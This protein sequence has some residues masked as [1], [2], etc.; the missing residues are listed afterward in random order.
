M[1]RERWTNVW[2][3]L[4]QRVVVF[5]LTTTVTSNVNYAMQY[6]DT[7]SIHTT[8]KYLQQKYMV[9]C[10]YSSGKWATAQINH[11][12]QHTYVSHIAL[13]LPNA[14]MRRVGQCPIIHRFGWKW[15]WWVWQNRR[16]QH[17]KDEQVCPKTSCH[18]IKSSQLITVSGKAKKL[19]HYIQ[20]ASG[21]CAA[22]WR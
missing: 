12:Q 4:R 1:R 13:F 14:K 17:A 20:G 8:A 5:V 19:F 15:K 22:R 2:L 7:Y 11:I 10:H 9:R 3:Q 18:N 16:T 21:E 6:P